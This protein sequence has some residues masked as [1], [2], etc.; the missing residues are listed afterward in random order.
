MTPAEWE[1]SLPAFVVDACSHWRLAPCCPGQLSDGAELTCKRRRA[2]VPEG[3]GILRLRGSSPAQ[4][5]LLD[6]IAPEIRWG[7]SG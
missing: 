6:T 7:S 5:E 4:D 1:C 2:E 3:K